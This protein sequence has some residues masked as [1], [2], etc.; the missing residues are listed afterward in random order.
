MFL[1]RSALTLLVAG[2]FADDAHD[3]LALHDLAVLTE[4]FD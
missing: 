4:A 2:V 1:L 3:I